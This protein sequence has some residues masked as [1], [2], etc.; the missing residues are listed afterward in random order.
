MG[1]GLN[2]VG[3][4]IWVYG[5]NTAPHIVFKQIMVFDIYL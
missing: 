3:L 5:Y 1:R 2:I 4:A